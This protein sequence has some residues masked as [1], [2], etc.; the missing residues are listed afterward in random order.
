MADPIT[1]NSELRTGENCW[2]IARAS[3]VSVIVD[4]ADYFAA[5]REAMLAAEHRIMLIGWD[6]DARIKLRPDE[7]IKLG[8]FVISLVKRRP[9]LEIY[10]LR[11]D[12]GALKTVFRGTTILT[13]ARWMLHKRIHTKLDSRHPTGGSH[14]Q[15]IV[16]IDDCFAFCGGID[17]TGDRW[18][19][20]CHADHEPHRRRPN[21]KP[22]PPWHDATTAL[23]GPVAAALGELARERWKCAGGEELAP[24]SGRTNCWPDGLVCQFTDADVAIARTRPEI[25]DLP[26][27]PAVREIE[28]LYL[29]QIA[30]ARRYIYAE[31]Q[32]FA[33]RRIAEAIARRLAE[34]DGPEIVIINPCAADGWLEQV[35]MDTARA[36]L[37]QALRQRDRNDRFRIYHPYTA[38]GV[39]IYVHAKILI[40]DDVILRVGSSNFNNRSLGLDTECD[41][42]IDA[43]LPPNSDTRPAIRAI[44]D[45]LVAEHLGVS[46]EA[47]AAQLDAC[48]SLIAAIERLAGPGRA[49]R[50]YEVPDLNAV[51][52]W[53]A[54]NEA[55]DPENPEEMYEP[56]ARRGLFRLLGGPAP[57]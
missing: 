3:K 17:M 36:R 10:L 54:D 23:E 26:D 37:C 47:V 53:L 39:P 8:D 4:A 55:L 24:V 7:E 43:R 6:F 52:A 11:W 27:L 45:G 49:L 29:D 13:L 21:G 12:M 18:D 41:V 48:G 31:S 33:S 32:Y 2:R 9:A 5:A 25:P 34:Q 35:A 44:R 14:H 20:R 38:A 57:P 15:K 51:E 28:Q 40:V 22:Y 16:V 50:S 56:F 42:T 1:E 19:T 30:T 46:P